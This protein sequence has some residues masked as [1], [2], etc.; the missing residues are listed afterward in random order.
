MLQVQTLPCHKNCRY[1]PDG[2][3]VEVW[4]RCITARASS[5][6]PRITSHR[7]DSGSSQNATAG[8]GVQ[9]GQWPGSGELCA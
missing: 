6:R 5:S 1:A 9:G 3:T 2:R 4:M 8:M 7:G